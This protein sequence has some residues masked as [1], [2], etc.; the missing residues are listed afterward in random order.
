MMSPRFLFESYCYCIKGYNPCECGVHQAPIK[1]FACPMQLD[2]PR[3]SCS[4]TPPPFF[5]S[6]CPLLNKILAVYVC[7]YVYSLPHSPLDDETFQVGIHLW[8]LYMYSKYISGL[9]SPHFL[10]SKERFLNPVKKKK[11]KEE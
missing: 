4:R 5:Q 8:T 9:S 2:I 11:K 1:E 6:K 3:L 10:R 7:V